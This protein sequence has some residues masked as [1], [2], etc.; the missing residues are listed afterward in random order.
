[1][2]ENVTSPK[3]YQF[4]VISSRNAKGTHADQNILKYFYLFEKERLANHQK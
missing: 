4:R 3:Q 1:M 2:Q